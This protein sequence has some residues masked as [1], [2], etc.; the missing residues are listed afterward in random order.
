MVAQG[1]IKSR[2]FSFHLNKHSENTLGGEIIFGGSDPSLFKGP[3]HYMPISQSGYWQI[4]MDKVLVPTPK[5]VFN[6]C[7]SRCEAIIDTGTSL[8][9]GPEDVIEPLNL[10]VLGA[11]KSEGGN[12]VVDCDNVDDLPVIT[13]VF[14]GVGFKLLPKSYILRVCL[15]M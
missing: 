10:S 11:V 9:T 8:I 7:N 5:G 14:G 13:F 6:L 3:M 1:L 2:I 4:H 15:N 12:Y